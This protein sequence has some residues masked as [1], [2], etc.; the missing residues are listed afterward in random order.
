[1]G[2]LLPCSSIPDKTGYLDSLLIWTGLWPPLC[3]PAVTWKAPLAPCGRKGYENK[4][5]ILSITW[6]QE[7]PPAPH[8]PGPALGLLHLWKS[9]PAPFFKVHLM[10]DKDIIEGILG[11]KKFLMYII[12]EKSGSSLK[13]R[14]FEI[15]ILPMNWKPPHQKVETWKNMQPNMGQRKE[16][17]SSLWQKTL[18][19]FPACLPPKPK[20]QSYCFCLARTIPVDR[21]A[22]IW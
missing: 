3:I 8:I 11:E 14:H 6:E 17:S 4:T 21:W 12:R 16:S 20:K 18:R 19:N 15:A 7:S 9:C 13:G 5:I 22:T 10:P 2:G 1:M